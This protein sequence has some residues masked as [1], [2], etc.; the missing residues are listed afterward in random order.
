ERMRVAA[1]LGAQHIGERGV[2]ILCGE[3]A[4]RRGDVVGPYKTLVIVERTVA[5]VAEQA[6]GGGLASDQI[7]LFRFVL[8]QLAGESQR[9]ARLAGAQQ[10]R[11]Q[12]ALRGAR[13]R[14][15]GGA[16]QRF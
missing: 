11:E 7:L 14:D 6:Q 2:E 4:A 12:V 9:V 15:F 1:M 13:R 8:A 5:L 3:I 10:S 16:L